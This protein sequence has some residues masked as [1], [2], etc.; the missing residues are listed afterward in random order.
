ME[1]KFKG[2]AG[3][4]KDDPRVLK[5]STTQVKNHPNVR[6]YLNIILINANTGEIP[7]ERLVNVE[8]KMKS[9]LGRANYILTGEISALSKATQGG[10]RSDYV[11]MSFQ[12]IEPSSNE[13]VWEDAYETKKVTNRGVLYK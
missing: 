1:D 5:V 6:K 10:D 7:I 2:T 11:I 8:R 13:I 12:M 9:G 4:S 3:R